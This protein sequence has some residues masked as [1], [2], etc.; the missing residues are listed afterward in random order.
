MVSVRFFLCT[1]WL[2][3]FSDLKT[4]IF[5]QLTFGLSNA[6]SGLFVDHSD[7]DISKIL[8]RLPQLIIWLWLHLLV[9]V[10]ANQRL[11]HSI[12]ED[13]INKPWRPLPA[14]RLT[15]D[16]ARKLLLFLVPL[17]L[18][19]ASV[20]GT[21][22]IS[23]ALLLATWMYNDLGGA[24]ENFFTRNVL[25]AVGLSLFG[26]G[27]TTIAAGKHNL[28]ER[29]SLWLGILAGVITCTVHVQDLP[30]LHGDAAR[31]RRTLPLMY[32]QWTARLSISFGIMVWSLICPAFWH[33]QF[34]A[35]VP[36]VFL[37]S[38]LAVRTIFL[39]EV[40]A[41]QITWRLWCAWMMVLYLL[42]LSN[43]HSSFF[44]S[45]RLTHDLYNSAAYITIETL[46]GK[47]I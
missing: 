34:L 41:N 7:P 12:M 21:S 9:E 29:L 17:V 38:V 15:A 39:W 13:A 20:W 44:I 46:K 35:Y 4:V 5:P 43:D 8:Y 19:C 6:L 40:K 24:D 28:N 42:P 25:N 45:T 33:V 1:L 37:G 11:P 31:G 23:G 22:T 30:D 36:S 47:F 18:L 10:I 3:T 32:G 16:E 27:A 26:A 2:F 14:A